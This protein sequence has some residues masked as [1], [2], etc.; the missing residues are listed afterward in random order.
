MTRES[1]NS[2]D[3]EMYL[4]ACCF[5]DPAVVGKCVSGGV[6]PESF[7]DPKHRTVFTVMLDLYLN[8]KPCEPYV[9]AEELKNR[10]ELEPM[11]GIAF[12]LQ[13]SGRYG[14]PIQAPL[15]IESIRQKATLRRVIK[16]SEAAIERC[17]AVTTDF[18]EAM[19]EIESSVTR[20]T[21]SGHEV[22][23]PTMQQV[24]KELHAELLL[25]KEQRK[26]VAP[27]LSWGL[28]DLDM[29]CGRL[30]PGALVVLAGMP[31]SGKSALADQVA[32]NSAGKLGQ[33]TLIFTYEMSKRDKAVRI[34][35]Q[36]SRLNYDQFDGAPCEMQDSFARATKAVMDCKNLHVFE[37]DVTVNRLLARVRAFA[38]RGKVGLIVVDFLQYLSRLE[39][40][41]G[42]ER[43]DEKLGRL[44]AAA[45]QIAGECG[46][47]IMLL[48]SLNRSAY[49]DGERPTMAGLK[50]SGE[51][52]SDADQLG[53]L[54]WPKQDPAGTEQD[55][56]DSMQSR[57]YVEFNQEKGRN[58]GVATVG[59]TF[60]RKITRFDNYSR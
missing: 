39:P 12:I 13:I 19:A 30:M 40:T 10:R 49:A 14:S 29:T 25:P 21:G 3:A 51:I 18:T 5:D 58:K 48:S 8:Q 16:E 17:H 41:I 44:T 1:P 26:A 56:H 59:L 45:K 20:A 32:W 50:N 37:R 31:S 36:Q 55:P 47:P 15:F 7:Y 33:T 54:H 23:E 43:T 35:Q 34:A 60:D 9:V 27:G 28:I 24:A 42:K 53:I 46:C 57:F 52:E 4:L 22:S 11:G 6:M 2:T 38:S